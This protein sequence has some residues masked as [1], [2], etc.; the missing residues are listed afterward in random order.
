MSNGD[1]QPENYKTSAEWEKESDFRV[2]DP[3]G[4]DRGS[5]RF[6]FSWFVELI[7][8]AEFN[9]RLIRSTC[10]GKHSVQRGVNR[11]K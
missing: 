6:H 3:D 9:R 2:L 5:N 8:E 10:I 11:G 7:T 4:W 1:C